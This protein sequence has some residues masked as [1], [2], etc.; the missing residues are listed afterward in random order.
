MMVRAKLTDAAAGAALIA[1]LL[2]AGPAAA[3]A[4]APAPS[5][6]MQ[7]VGEIHVT[8]DGG[9]RPIVAGKIDGQPVKMLVDTGA[10]DNI[11]IFAAA[12]R[13]GL[14][15][16]PVDGLRA[17]GPG[18]IISLNVV[19]VREL[20]LD[21]VAI[22]NVELLVPREGGPADGPDI[23]GLIGATMFWPYDVEFD[24]AAGAIRFF[25]SDC[26]GDE[27]VYWDGAYS[28]AAMQGGSGVVDRR[29]LINVTLNGRD[30]VAKLDTGASA[31]IVTIDAAQRAKVKTTDGGVRAD[32]T[33]DGGGKKLDQW[34]ATFD[35][36][37]AGDE[38]IKNAKIRIAD[39][40]GAARE[41]QTGSRV[42]TRQDN[43]ASMILGADFFRAHRV[44][45]SNRQKRVY[46]SYRGG[47]VFNTLGAD[48]PTPN[49]RP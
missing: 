21:S 28:V 41:I 23:A 29:Y 44:M 11:L 7:T 4:A 35:S 22:P 48:A 24:L 18:G 14:K 40:Y 32:G 12:D 43:S 5:C 38:V 46:F 3:A 30:M 15:G 34:V 37:G 33:I 27:L 39:L 2:S 20:Q 19:T 16:V 1:T 8:L 42:A 10:F 49:L 6:K 26:K 9:G 13:M 25:K 45:I 31:S 17:Y 47:P 36:F